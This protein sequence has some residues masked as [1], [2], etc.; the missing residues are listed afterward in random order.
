LRHSSTF[1]SFKL[2]H[3]TRMVTY[4]TIPRFTQEDHEREITRAKQLCRSIP[5]EKGLYIDFDQLFD[6]R[7]PVHC[8]I[9]AL[10]HFVLKKWHHGRIVVIGE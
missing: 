5:R 9:T 3:E 8:G 4:D 7:S 6:K 2:P 10:P 1:W